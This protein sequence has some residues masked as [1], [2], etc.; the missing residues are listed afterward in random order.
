MRFIIFNKNLTIRNKKKG[1]NYIKICKKRIEREL[2]LELL[3]FKS[4]L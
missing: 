4:N 2:P 3:K 1:F